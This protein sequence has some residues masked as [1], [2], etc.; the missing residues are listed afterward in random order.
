[1]RE[2][3][4]FIRRPQ[5]RDEHYMNNTWDVRCNGHYT[6]RGFLYFWRWNWRKLERHLIIG[7]P[8]SDILYWEQRRH[9]PNDWPTDDYAWLHDHW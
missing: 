1:M 3:R 8:V 9:D 4:V 2:Y 7:F 5:E 6:D